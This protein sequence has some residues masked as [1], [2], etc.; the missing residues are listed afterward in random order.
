MDLAKQVMN[1]VFPIILFH[2]YLFLFAAL[3]AKVATESGFPYIKVISPEDLVGYTEG[4][5]CMKITKVFEDA[6]KSPLSLVIVDDIERLLDYVR[7]GPR[8]SNVVL[9]TLLVLFK[10]HPPKVGFNPFSLYY[11]SLTHCLQGKKLLIIGTTSSRDV[12]EDMEFM[13][14]F[15]AVVPLPLVR[16]SEVKTV[17]SLYILFHKNTNLK[18]CRCYENLVVSRRQI[19]K[20]YLPCAAIHLFQLR[21]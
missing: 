12:L 17:R 3:A 7:I 20:R 11:P 14:S 2:S 21:N 16:G 15:D 10:K 9:Q 1:I 6:Y 8:F 19:S 13:S 5:K 4:A 18:E